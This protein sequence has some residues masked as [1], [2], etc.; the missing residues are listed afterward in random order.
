MRKRVLFVLLLA[1]VF[2][3]F[4]IEQV[5]G[6]RELLVE[7]VRGQTPKAKIT[8][9]INAVSNGDQEQAF[10]VWDLPVR[11][12]ASVL[13]AEYFDRLEDQR[14]TTTRD[15]I[16]KKIKPEF[17]IRNIEWWSTCCEPRI[18]KNSRVAGHAKF[19]VDLTDSNNVKSTYIFDVSV[20]G[21]YD[22]GLT[23]HYVRHW[24]I[25]SVSLGN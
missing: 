1:S 18:I 15:L 21:G 4:F 10:M 2:S 8:N 24:K 23:S 14:E 12:E 5:Y 3:L 9:Y 7:I 16:A 22:G 19:Y 17:E 25:D 6:A 11:D 20:P 13:S